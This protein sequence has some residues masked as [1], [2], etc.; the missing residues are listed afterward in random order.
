MLVINAVLTIDIARRSDVIAAAITMQQ[1]SQQE[2]GCHHY[3]FSA[4]LER[5]DVMHIAEKWEDQAALDAHFVTPHMAI[6]QAILGGVVKDIQATK[7]VIA[8]EG[9]IR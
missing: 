4:D 1:A 9:P 7:Y 2:P 6:F 5:D 8:S 3:V